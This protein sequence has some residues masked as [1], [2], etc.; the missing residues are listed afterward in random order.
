MAENLAVERNIAVLD[1]QTDQPSLFYAVLDCVPRQKGYTAVNLK[2]ANEQRGI[3]ALERRRKDG[4]P[5][6]KAAVEYTAIVIL[7]GKEKRLR[8]QFLNRQLFSAQLLAQRCRRHKYDFLALL[9]Q[10]VP[11]VA[12]QRLIEHIDHVQLA[13][14]HV[15]DQIFRLT[16]RDA[17]RH[18]RVEFA[19]Q[20][21]H[22]RQLETC[23]RLNRADMQRTVQLCR[24]C[25]RHARLIDLIHHVARMAE[26]TLAR[27]GQRD[28]L[29]HAV[30]QTRVQFLLQLTYLHRY[31][32]L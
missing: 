12:V 22:C 23:K 15:L 26:K 6:G 7:L 1:R 16:D 30:E 20:M 31:R 24:G 25:D 32:R 10:L 2:H 17:D 13:A 27:V 28:T 4:P 9:H 11:V 3:T 5:R 21:Q 8:E 29:A 14:F 19:V 18:F